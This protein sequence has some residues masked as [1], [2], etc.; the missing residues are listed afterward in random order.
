MTESSF[1]LLPQMAFL[2]TQ[3]QYGDLTE[4]KPKLMIYYNHV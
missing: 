3:Q 4:D 1:P 2:V